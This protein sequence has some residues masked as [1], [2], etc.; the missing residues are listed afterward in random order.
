MPWHVAQS[1][2]SAAACVKALPHKGNDLE[3]LSAL[4]RFEHGPSLT[5]VC[6]DHMWL[7]EGCHGA[8]RASAW[9]SHLIGVFVTQSMLVQGGWGVGSHLLGGICAQHAQRVHGAHFTGR[10]RGILGQL[11]TF[12]PISINLHCIARFVGVDARS[13]A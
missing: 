9:H 12:L 6:L 5:A 3:K 8:M 2:H 11:A 7:S 4:T 10:N 1:Q 13:V